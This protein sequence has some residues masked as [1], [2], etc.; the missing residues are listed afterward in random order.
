MC[1]NDIMVKSKPSAKIEVKSAKVVEEKQV[2]TVKRRTMS[3][4]LRI[5]LSILLMVILSVLFVWFIEY[6][7]AL[8][9]TDEAW[10][11]VTERYLVFWYSCVLMFFML[12]TVVSLLWRPFFGSGLVFVIISI[13]SYI[14]MQKFQ[15]RSAPL[16][17]EDFQMVGQAGEIMQ[18]VDPWSVTRLVLGSIFILV[19]SGLLEHYARKLFGQDKSGLEW[20]KRW[21]IAPRTAF[22][23]L[24][25]AGLGLS[26]SFI[27]NHGNQP[28]IKVKWLDTEFIA[29]NQTVNYDDNG[30]IMGFLYNLGRSQ[31]EEPENYNT[32]TIKK[33]AQKYAKLKAADDTEREP[34]SKIVDNVI[35]VMNESF[36][37]PEIL[38]DHYAH[39]GGDVVPN[40]HTLFKKYP[41]GY[42]YSPEYGGNTANIEFAAFTGL[43][44]YWANDVP[45]VNSVSKI[46]NMPGLVSF[47][48]AD[49]FK[50]TAIHSFDGTMYKR[51]IV[52][53]NMGF[54]TFLDKSSMKHQELENDKGYISDRA[55]YQE[56]L[57]VLN[58]GEKNHMVGAVTMQNHVPFDSAQYEDYHFTLKNRVDNWYGAESS[59]ESL[60]RSDQYLGEFIE[61][62]DKLE[63][64]TVLIW[65]GDHAAGVLDHYASS[66]EKELRDLA[67][68]TPYFIYTNFEVEDPYTIKE[69]AEMNKALGFN[70]P[71]KGVD[72]PTVTPNCLA[73]ELY[74][75][76]GAKK[77]SMMYLVD[78]VCE[79]TPVLTANYFDGNLPE[80]TGVLGEYQLVN[81]DILNGDRYYLAN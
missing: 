38:G 48:K 64:R 44:N 31:L 63:G 8:N 41:S 7:R 54:D 68:M 29:W 35:L 6:R 55:V 45:Y 11:F 46:S 78:M 66:S 34:L 81:Y 27:I 75:L 1:Y 17:P 16:V 10:E 77:P 74:D 32:E 3:P 37:D 65:F 58:D 24:S 13:L 76:L 67:H 62:L 23:M 61:E 36:Y 56:I 22:T 19:G 5:G 21:N 49:N 9:D 12:A 69:V 26:S 73:N 42:M 60:H 47:T 53:N 71:T 70:F 30:F 2:K 14:N 80:N 39:T 33:I 20:W 72:L 4:F 79:T 59:F 25:L 15:F 18:F 57:D 40:L 51:N 50:T 43:S 52:Y 28:G